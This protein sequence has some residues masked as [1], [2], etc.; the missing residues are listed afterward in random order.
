SYEL[1]ASGAA[2]TLTLGGLTSIA[3]FGN[4]SPLS[5]TL[6]ISA[7]QGGQVQLPSLTIINPTNNGGN[8]AL[9]FSADDAASIVNASALTSYIGGFGSTLSVTNSGAVLGTALTQLDAVDLN[10]DGTGTLSISQWT[11]YIDAVATISG[12]TETFTNLANITNSS[13]VV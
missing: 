4:V 1:Q 2:S 8:G 13:F 11:G 6:E 7:Q 10:L 12:G 5:I 3:N 9:S